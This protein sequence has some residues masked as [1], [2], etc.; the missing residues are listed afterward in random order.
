MTGS[1]EIEHILFCIAGLVQYVVSSILI[2][3]LKLGRRLKDVNIVP[4]TCGTYYFLF[5]SIDYHYVRRRFST[6]G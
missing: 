5:L 6:Q 3:K 4:T 1:V 2:C